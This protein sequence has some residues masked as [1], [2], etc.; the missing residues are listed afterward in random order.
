MKKHANVGKRPTKDGENDDAD[1]PA[2]GTHEP[3][4]RTL[5]LYLHCLADCL[6]LRLTSATG[7]GSPATVF[8]FARAMTLHHETCYILL[9]RP[10][11]NS[12]DMRTLVEQDW[13][14]RDNPDS[15]CAGG[16]EVLLG[17]VG[18]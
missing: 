16:K 4:R 12:P 9:A 7:P 1:A 3:D 6:T 11:G 8:S 18:R 10:A 17:E 13:V 2:D 15:E 5:L 14:R